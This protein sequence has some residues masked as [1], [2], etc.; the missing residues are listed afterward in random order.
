VDIIERGD[1]ARRLISDK[2]LT[3]AM[4]ELAET[5][6]RSWRNAETHDERELAWAKDFAL[7]EIRR[8]LTTWAEDADIARQMADQEAP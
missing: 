3:D 5:F 8:V 7:G 4:D 2:N 1:A 6:I